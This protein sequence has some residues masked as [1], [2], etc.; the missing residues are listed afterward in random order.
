MAS[1]LTVQRL[2]KLFSFSESIPLDIWHLFQ[3]N[4]VGAEEERR[5]LYRTVVISEWGGSWGADGHRSVLCAI[6]TLCFC[7]SLKLFVIK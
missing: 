6:Y 1:I 2:F 4:P 7:G 5:E 3:N